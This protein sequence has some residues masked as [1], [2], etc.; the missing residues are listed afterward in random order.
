M[1]PILLLFLS[2]AIG[3]AQSSAEW[4]KQGDALDGIGKPKQALEAYEKALAKDPANSGILVKIAKQYGDMM[5]SLSGG[6][7]KSAGEKSLE[8]SRKAVAADP[9][10]SDSHLA[11]ALSLGKNTEFMGNKAKLQ[12]SREMKSEA[13][14]ALRL[15][16]KSDYAHHLLGRWHQEMAGI[17]GASRL[18]AKAIYGGVPNGSYDQALEHFK[19]A[20][21]INSRRLIHQVEYGRT[22]A[23]M[24]RKAE[25]RTEIQKGLTMPNREADDPESKQR[26]RE[27]LDKL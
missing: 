9:N 10:S 18:I 14:T 12:A 7:K 1:K 23:M 20:R 4:K 24:D 11:V 5:P 27:T 17:G 19:K 6:A 8:Y 22:L 26:G 21:S 2:T 15:N 3:L 13:D 25:A 16:S